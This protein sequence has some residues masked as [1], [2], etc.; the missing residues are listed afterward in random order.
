MH[1]C[2]PGIPPTYG[3][4]GCF[5]LLSAEIVSVWLHILLHR[6][7][8][9]GELSHSRIKMLKQRY[10]LTQN[11]CWLICSLPFSLPVPARAC[12]CC[13]HARVHLMA[14]LPCFASVPHGLPSWRALK[15]DRSRIVCFCFWVCWFFFFFKK[16]TFIHRPQCLDLP[17]LPIGA[18]A[19]DAQTC[20]RHCFSAFWHLSK[21]IIA[22]LVFHL[23]IQSFNVI[24]GT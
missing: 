5:S 1:L 6:L 2:S 22:Y 23:S 20:L 15:V 4:S 8:K 9:L 7:L 10:R 3:Y 13:S 11:Q 19:R 16:C 24:T 12:P 18:P 14:V 17:T 21:K